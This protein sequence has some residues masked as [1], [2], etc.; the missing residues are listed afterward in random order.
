M[1]GECERVRDER[2][3]VLAFR[4]VYQ[5]NNPVNDFVT[6]RQ[7][8]DCQQCPAGVLITQ[9]AGRLAGT[10]GRNAVRQ[11]GRLRAQGAPRKAL[12]S[13]Q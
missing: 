12:R 8:K 6:C 11:G 5:T 7:A 9:F 10:Q 13:R 2:A 1:M 4:R 3:F